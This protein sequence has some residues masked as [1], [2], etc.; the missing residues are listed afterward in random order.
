MSEGNGNGQPN[1]EGEPVKIGNRTFV[2]PSL[3]TSQ[4]KKLWPELITIN[5]GVTVEN[6]PE[7][8]E[9]MLQILHAAISRN[10]PELT[11]DE[12]ADLVSVSQLADLVVKVA[13]QSGFIARPGGQ[14]TATQNPTQ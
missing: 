13:E 2:I 9:R 6:V 14:P 5:Q 7:R 3:S 8:N 4:A 10:V 1:Y 11:V 12:L